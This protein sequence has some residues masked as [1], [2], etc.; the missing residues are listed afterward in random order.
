MRYAVCNELFGTTPLASAAR[1]CR[2]AGYAGIEFAPYTVFG[3]FSAQAVTA[4]LSRIRTALMDEGLAFAGFHW[5]FVGPEGMHITTPDPGPRRRARDHLCRLV[6]AA[7]ELGGGPLI[8]GSP[9]Q[10]SATGGMDP[11]AAAAALAREL[12]LVAPY[13]AERG[14]AILLEALPSDQCDVVTTLAQARAII[15]GIASP[16]VSGMFDFHNTRDE[17]DPWP[18]LVRAHARHTRHVHANEMDGGF[19]GTGTSDFAPAI[20]ALRETGYDAWVSMEIFSVPADPAPG[21]VAAR[22]LLESAAASRNTPDAV[23]ERQDREQDD[24]MRSAPG[25]EGGGG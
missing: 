14:C 7:A 18:E 22:E 21:L 25:A 11:A 9:R 16:G 19:P 4:G 17:T 12:A 3:D 6:D 15:D 8:L 20:Q 13:A 24:G 5:L 10:R 23:G 2:L 1:I